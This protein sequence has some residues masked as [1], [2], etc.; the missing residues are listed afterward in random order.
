MLPHVKNGK[1]RAI[2]MT[3]AKRSPVIGDVP[4]VAEAGVKGYESGSWYGIVAPANTPR[5]II[6]RLNKEIVAAVKSKDIQDRLNNEAVTPA[7][8]TPEEFSAHIKAEY[9]RM[10][11]VIREAKITLD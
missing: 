11:R 6:D 8:N 5:P 2:A 10:A 1:L 3:G 4:T 9:E 7:G